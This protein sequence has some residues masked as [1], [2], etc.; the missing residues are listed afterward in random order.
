MTRP[1]RLPEPIA[2]LWAVNRERVIRALDAILLSYLVY[3]FVHWWGL[4]G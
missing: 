3:L 1:K 2:W 4:G